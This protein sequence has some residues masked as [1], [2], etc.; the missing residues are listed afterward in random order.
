[1]EDHPE[2]LRALVDRVPEGWTA[3]RYRGRGYGLRRTSRA[4]GRSVAIYA[5]ELG[6]ADVVSTNVYRTS[7]GDVLKPCEMPASTVLAFLAGWQPAADVAS[8]DPARQPGRCQ[9]RGSRPPGTTESG[10]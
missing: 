2:D 1:M 10:A 5:E 8:A 3:A 6:G 7:A 4:E 9:P